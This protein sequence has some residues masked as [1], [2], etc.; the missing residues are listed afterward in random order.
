MAKALDIL[1]QM[2][3]HLAALKVPIQSCR[4]DDTLLR[5][6]LL[7]GLFLHAAVLLPTGEL[8]ACSFYQGCCRMRRPY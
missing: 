4:K 2:R 1:H 7:S 5:R 3:Q 8:L 6:A